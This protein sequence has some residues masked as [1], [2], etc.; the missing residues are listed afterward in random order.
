[1]GITV[2][3]VYAIGKT[4]LMAKGDYKIVEII[5]IGD[6]YAICYEPSDE[7]DPIPG[8]Y[9]LTVKKENGEIGYLP[10]P[11]VENIERL[12]KGKKVDI[13]V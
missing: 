9:P 12:E 11:P 7:G 13:P 5:D 1:M 8:D 2:E 4:E 3:E 6:S 10:I